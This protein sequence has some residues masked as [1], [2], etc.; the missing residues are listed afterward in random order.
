MSNHYTI[1]SILLAEDDRDDHLVFHSA[2]M[3]IY[4][5][6]QLQRVSDGMELLS[7]LNNYIPELLFLK[8]DMPSKNGLECLKEI[9]KYFTLNA[10][11]MV[12]KLE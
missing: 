7:L 2:L 1:Q 10:L 3:T 12:V 4:P 9:R 11:P 5:E 8:M 6:Q